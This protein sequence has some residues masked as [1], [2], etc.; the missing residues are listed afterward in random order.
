MTDLHDRL[1][2][3]ADR[4]PDRAD[5]LARLRTARERRDRRRARSALALGLVIVV[6]GSGVALTA[7]RGP[8]TPAPG[9]ETPGVVA[10]SPPDTPYLWPENWARTGAR[11]EIAAVQARAD[12][13][14]E[15]VGWR[16]DPEEV[17]RRFAE[18][19][20]AWDAPDV[21]VSVMDPADGD[22]RAYVVSPVSGP[23]ADLPP[24]EVSVVQ[25]LRGGDAGIWGVYA[26]TSEPLGIDVPV[27]S[28]TTALTAGSAIDLRLSL[29]DARAGH[30]GLVASN[31]C[32]ES[33][34]FAPALTSGAA[35]L[36][37]PPTEDVPESCGAVGAGYAFI[38]AMDDTTV[39]V[40]DPLLEA[41][42][43]EYPWL[44]MLPVYVQ[45]RPWDETPDAFPSS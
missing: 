23:H 19:V 26:V 42:A 3:L 43:I 35:S 38:Y 27:T 45:M 17:A 10:W 37:V 15:S 25:P 8:Q 40:G 41:A 33:A 13:G 11:D 30:A 16:L 20:L 9:T 22:V 32:S 5:A 21:A 31:D 4:A 44:T 18:V 28:P 2:R 12:A 36:E 24:I 6:V 29:P 1:E 14:D 7:L 39:A 34:A